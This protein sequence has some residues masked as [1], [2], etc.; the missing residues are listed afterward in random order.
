MMRLSNIF[1]IGGIVASGLQVQFQQQREFNLHEFE[2]RRPEHD[3]A[4]RKPVDTGKGCCGEEH[5]TREIPT[6]DHNGKGLK[7]DGRVN[8]VDPNWKPDSLP[9][10]NAFTDGSTKVSENTPLKKAF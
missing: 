4:T 8:G 2:K 3:G 7:N 6:P 1:L 9:D 10:P 5:S